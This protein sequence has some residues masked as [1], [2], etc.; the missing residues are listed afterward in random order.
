MMYRKISQRS[1]VYNLYSKKLL[2]QKIITSDQIQSKW[3]QQIYKLK[4]A[5]DEA[6]HESFDV[7]KLFF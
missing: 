1:N 2:D 3:D 6:L 5:Y 7:R 4:S